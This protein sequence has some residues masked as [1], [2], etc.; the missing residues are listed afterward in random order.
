MSGSPFQARVGRAFVV[1]GVAIVVGAA[2]VIAFQ[3][4]TP[5]PAPSLAR[6]A[7]ALG[8][9]A[10][11]NEPRALV[12]NAILTGP[13]ASLAIYFDTTFVGYARSLDGCTMTF[14]VIETITDIVS[15]QLDRAPHMEPCVLGFGLLP[16]TFDRWITSQ[17]NGSATGV[18][19]TLGIVGIDSLGVA[20]TAIRVVRP[21]IIGFD[22][23]IADAANANPV[24][25]AA[26]ID[27]DSVETASPSAYPT[28]GHSQVTKM[29]S[30]VF[31]LAINN[32]PVPGAI[33]VSAIKIDR[34]DVDHD[35]PGPWDVS[36]IDVQTS[37]SKQGSFPKWYQSELIDS[38]TPERSLSLVFMSAALANIFEID[39]GGV[40]L[41]RVDSG[42]GS[43]RLFSMYAETAATVFP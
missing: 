28:P 20:V 6:P 35:A 24:F 22:V 2:A 1:A 8:S 11:G 14:D 37:M 26:T 30:S 43:Q 23:P 36:N 12:S 39:L 21:L 29:L 9:R 40:G 38:G 42:L 15:K 27:G 32:V 34:T 4:N 18:A 25:F 10:L 7:A 41:Y 19:D 33:K 13:I 17:L 16:A 3:G 5:R 31:R